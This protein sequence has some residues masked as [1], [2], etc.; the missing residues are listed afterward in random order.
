MRT[1]QFCCDE[2]RGY[3]ELYY[4]DQCGNGMN[5]FHGARGQRGHGLGSVLSGL[6]RSALPMIKNI[7]KQALQTGIN[8]ATDVVQGN[9]FKDSLRKHVP[10]GIRGFRDVQFGQSGSGKRRRRTQLKKTCETF[11]NRYN[12]QRLN[13]F[14]ASS[15]LRVHEE[16]IGYFHRSSY[17]N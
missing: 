9:T 10:V 14:C 2:N 12:I 15:I 7:G 16:R 13:G 1:K 11:K 5:V 3:Y 17:S 4:A 8:V 6:F